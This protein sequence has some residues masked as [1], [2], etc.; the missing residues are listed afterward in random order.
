MS[1]DVERDETAAP[2]EALARARRFLEGAQTADGR[3]LDFRFRFVVGDRD[4]ISSQWVT[5]YV[6]EALGRAGGD[7]AAL[8]RARDWLGAHPHPGGAWGF[9][10]ATPEDAD[11]TAN[12]VHFLSRWRGAPAWD[13]ALAHAGMQL[14]RFWDETEGGFRTYRPAENPSLTGW[15]SYP[16]SSWCDVHLSVSA[17]ASWAL[18]TTGDARYHPVL[19]R[20]TRMVR[21]RQAPEGFWEAYWWQ[22]RTYATFHAARLLSL[23]GGDAAAVARAA[24]WFA[25]TQHPSGGWG[26]G[27]GGEPAPFHTALA[28]STL[29][30]D[31]GGQRH[32]SALQA[33]LRWLL[34]AQQ[35]DGGWG[36]VPI[37]R[38]PRPEVHAPW[39][40]PE[41][42]LLLPVLTDRNRLFTTATVVSTL[43]D[44]TKTTHIP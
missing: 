1:A 19:E 28:L 26:N 10:L 18:H 6:G 35:A 22:G 4:V 17:L 38:M 5:A 43:A 16:G 25:H 44:F 14:L 20:C 3:W 37:M 34:Q 36:S 33:G 12:V 40:D 31:G 13:A 8:E 9:S 42:C 41:G 39:E 32:T 23:P 11:S 15:A 29:L 27:T 21:A 24:Q 7:T 2:P 30:L